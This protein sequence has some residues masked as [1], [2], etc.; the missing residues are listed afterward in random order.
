MKWNIS[1]LNVLAGGR[2]RPLRCCGSVMVYRFQLLAE[3]QV[4]TEIFF[5]SCYELKPVTAGTAAG[6]NASHLLKSGC[7]AQPGAAP[8]DLCRRL[9]SSCTWLSSLGKS[10]RVSSGIL[11]LMANIT[12]VSSCFLY[13]RRMLQIY[14]RLPGGWLTCSCGL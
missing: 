6:K 14:V 11:T 10:E 3:L 5:D 12:R 2:T 8:P 7:A 4:S 13:S 9:L 1:K